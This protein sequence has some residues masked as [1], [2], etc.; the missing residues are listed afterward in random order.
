[1]RQILQES[2]GGQPGFGGSSAERRAGDYRGPFGVLLSHAGVR[3]I[4]RAGEQQRADD[5]M[6]DAIITDIMRG[7]VTLTPVTQQVSIEPEVIA[8]RELVYA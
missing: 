7:E 2:N 8:D 6:I 1:M 4:Q 3:L 5:L